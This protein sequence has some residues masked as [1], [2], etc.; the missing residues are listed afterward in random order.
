MVSPKLLL[1]LLPLA[2]ILA[3]LSY[4]FGPLGLIVLAAIGAMAYAS[5]SVLK[6]LPPF[7]SRQQAVLGIIASVIGS[8]LLLFVVATR[9]TATPETASPPAIARPP[10][11]AAS[12]SKTTA[13]TDADIAEMQRQALVDLAA[14][15]IRGPKK[16]MLKCTREQTGGRAVWV[17]T[18]LGSYALNGHAVDF[19]QRNR[20]SPR[21]VMGWDGKP[22]R[23]AREEFPLSAQNELIR[24]GLERCD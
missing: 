21:P 1:K 3:V 13:P 8:G 5:I 19:V 7:K 18:E 23:L 2:A 10:E 16:G 24:R 9:P 11:D 6:P 20:K 17:D 14:M 15:G 22:W 12:L 4:I